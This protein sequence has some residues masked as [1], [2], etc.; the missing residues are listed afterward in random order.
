MAKTVTNFEID[1]VEKHKQLRENQL[2]MEMEHRTMQIIHEKKKERQEKEYHTMLKDITDEKNFKFENLH[3]DRKQHYQKVQ[4][5]YARLDKLGYVAFEDHLI[6]V[7]ARQEQV[8][9]IEQELA[10]EAHARS[11]QADRDYVNRH[12]T[13]QAQID[14]EAG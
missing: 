1:R 4:D 2:V 9:K 12:I 7:E 3:V 13:L 10:V 8:K 6:E 14:L 11:T 5:K